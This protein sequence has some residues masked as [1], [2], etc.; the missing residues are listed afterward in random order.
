MGLSLLG[1]AAVI[2]STGVVGIWFG[3]ECNFF[4]FV[5]LL[6]GQ[7]SEESEG[8]I[9]YFIIQGLGSALIFIGI[10]FILME[11]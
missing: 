11:Y 7:T 10:C 6:N 9:K 8:G 5:P 2:L 1:T 4:G 3:L